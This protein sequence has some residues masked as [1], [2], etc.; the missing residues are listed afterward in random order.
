M[1]VI[2]WPLEGV[3]R[4]PLEVFSSRA[5]YD[6]EQRRIFRGETWN[7][8]G[9]EAEIPRPGD[10]KATFVGDTPIVLART[11]DSRISAMVNRCTHKGTLLCVEPFVN[12]KL[13]TCVYHAWSFDLD[14]NLLGVPFRN[15]VNGKGGM[16]PDFDVADFGLERLRVETI[17]GLVFATFSDTVAP[18]ESYLGPKMSANIRRVIDRPVRVLG[19]QHQMLNNNWKLYMENARDPYHATILH[20]FYPTFKLNKLNMEGGILL[21]EIGRHAITYSK[22]ATDRTGEYEGSSLRS[23][24]TDFGLADA[25]VIESRDERHDGITIAVQSIFPSFVLHQIYNSMAVRQLVP[26]GPDR[27]EL[28]WTFFGYEDDDAEIAAIRRKQANLVGSAGYVSME[29]GAV[30]GFIQRGIA[31]GSGTQAVLEL[32]MSDDANEERSRATES[33]LRGFWRGYRA[34]MGI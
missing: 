29:D 14:G 6:E 23:L 3:R 18:L 20:A 17:A 16:P 2:E 8:L 22:S 32:G 19:Y 24:M 10:M 12:K 26:L 7:Y 31:G 27:A 11:G 21:D 13:L 1:S 34:A 30:G 9:V 33:S 25:T 5:I 28:H 4:V 15:G